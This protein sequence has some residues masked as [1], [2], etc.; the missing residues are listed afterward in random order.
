MARVSDDVTNEV[1][2][3]SSECLGRRRLRLLTPAPGRR[4]WWRLK[5]EASGLALSP[6]V[7]DEDFFMGRRPNAG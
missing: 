6:H 1:G 2:A 4:F 7:R 3:P 5:L